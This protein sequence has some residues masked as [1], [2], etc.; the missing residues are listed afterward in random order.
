MRLHEARRRHE[1]HLPCLYLRET[2]ECDVGAAF[3]RE[4]LDWE[5]GM[6]GGEGGEDWGD[7]TYPWIRD[8]ERGEREMCVRVEIGGFF[9]F[10]WDT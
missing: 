8:R 6:G 7:C 9:G 3:G 10:A 2:K 1:P 4:L 5:K